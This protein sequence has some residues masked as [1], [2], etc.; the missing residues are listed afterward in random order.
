MFDRAWGR[1]EILLLGFVLALHL[2][3]HGESS[4]QQHGFKHRGGIVP[5]DA[6]V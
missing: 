1:S 2:A 5:Q 6:E 3:V 4:R